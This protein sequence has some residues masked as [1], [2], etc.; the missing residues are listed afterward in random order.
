MAGLLETIVFIIYSLLF[1]SAM[2]AGIV[3]MILVGM[4]V[5]NT[6]FRRHS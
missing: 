3:M 5:W 4:A 1:W 2:V 6:L